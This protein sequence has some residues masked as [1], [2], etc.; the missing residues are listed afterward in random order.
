M[1]EGL[2][3]LLGA[4]VADAAARP[5]HWVYDPK[6][7]KNYIKGKKDIAFFR[8]NKC[9]FYSI[10]LGA[11]SGYND[12]AQVM[13]QTIITSK[14]K[15]EIIENF[16]K[17]LVTHFG[18]GSIYFKNL[19]ERRKYKKKKWLKPLKGN[20]IHQNTLVAIQKI[21]S[22]KRVKG[23]LKVVQ[24]T[25]GFN[26]AI[27]YYFLVSKDDKE[28]KKV[29]RIAADSHLNEVYGLARLKII[30]LASQREKNPIQKFIK[31]NKKNKYFKEVVKDIQKVLKLKNQDHTK[32]TR[33][34][35][36]AC[37]DPG[38]FKSSVHCVITSSNYEQAIIKTIKAGGCNV[39]RAIFCGSYF[40]ALK[41]RNIPL[42]WIKKT[43]PAKKILEY[44]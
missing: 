16:K 12:M 31:L 3:I 30:D 35:G 7:L 4:T 13:F 20:W 6:K 27:P 11:V 17:N 29:I 43:I 5:L 14:K 15:L 32:V 28:V 24:E 26:A 21:K 41:D 8:E 2:K 37:S 44:I 42:A 1:Y 36:K 25:D 19:N 23:G 18:P 9:P 10:P 40:T 39:S 33:M 22:K 38:N 34:L